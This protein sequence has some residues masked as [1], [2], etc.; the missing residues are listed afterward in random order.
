MENALIAVMAIAMVF[1][2][3]QLLI[4]LRRATSTDPEEEK[5]HRRSSPLLPRDLQNLKIESP[6]VNTFD[7]ATDS[8]V[9]PNTKNSTTI[10]HTP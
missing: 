10:H 4:K 2:G 7:D 1:L 6:P 5:A 9:P 8:A 3:V